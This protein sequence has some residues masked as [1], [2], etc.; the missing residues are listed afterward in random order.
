MDN[1]IE[2]VNLV[3]FRTFLDQ[4]KVQK[5]FTALE[6]RKISAGRLYTLALTL[7]KSLNFLIDFC[8]LNKVQVSLTSFPSWN[9]V[10]NACKT[11]K[12]SEKRRVF[13]RRA[14]GPAPTNTL[15][16]SD[17]CLLFKHCSSFLEAHKEV[18]EKISHKK[19]KEF[20]AH[21]VT[22]LFVSVPPP[23]IQV[24]ENLVVNSTF[25]F[26]ES[27]YY[28]LFD[29]LNPPLK[30][31][32]PLLLVVPDHLTLYFKLW[33]ERWRPSGESQ[34]V[35]PNKLGTGPRRDWRELTMMVTKKYVNKAISPGKFR[36][37]FLSNYLLETH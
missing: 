19:R 24:L 30:S 26:D 34:Y 35:F 16:Q 22:A 7:M 32:K 2:H 1:Q 10:L 21:L 36:F 3:S 28:F 9:L 20:V 8:G 25:L 33:L 23:R 27:V 12:I 6:A 4:M 15:S 5:L 29:G 31:R 18:P 17:L 11:Y 37:F 13:S 14:V